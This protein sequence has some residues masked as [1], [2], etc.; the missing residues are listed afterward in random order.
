M[1]PDLSFVFAP[2][3]VRH[4]MRDRRKIPTSRCQRAR[5]AV[6]SYVENGWPSRLNCRFELRRKVRWLLDRLTR[7]PH[8]SGHHRVVGRKKISTRI[9]KARRQLPV[10]TEVATLLI[11]DS[12]ITEVV[13]YQPDHRNLIL[14]SGKHSARVHH[15]C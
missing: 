14:D 5:L 10:I 3:K 11:P 12:A 13:P 8:G 15:E 9:G 4:G 6:D 7:R 2:P 1:F